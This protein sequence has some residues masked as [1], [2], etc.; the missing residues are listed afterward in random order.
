[1]GMAEVSIFPVILTFFGAIL[2][3]VLTVLIGPWVAERF[4]LREEYFV[5]FQKW[6]TEF[7]GDFE[8]FY[9]RYILKESTNSY[10]EL[11]DILVILDYRSLH[12]TLIHSSQYHF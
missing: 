12:D 3:G 10:S 8:E 2:G 9:T 4:K 6:C 11:S 5:P 1:M 7:Y